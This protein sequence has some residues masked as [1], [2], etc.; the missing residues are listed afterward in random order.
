MA[1]TYIDGARRPSLITRTEIVHEARSWIGT[2][3]HH[4]ASGKGIATDCLGLIRGLYRT[5][6]GAEPVELPAYSPDW[7]EASGEETLLD[8]ARRTLIPSHRSEVL[9]GSVILFRMSRG[10]IA[11]HAGIATSEVTF[12]HAAERVGTV[13]VPLSAWWRRRIAGVF[14]FPGQED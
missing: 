10:S 9:P 6:Y 11:K 5:L 8:A 1:V 2:P 12:V 13:E 7:G 14:S 4:Q 3:Y